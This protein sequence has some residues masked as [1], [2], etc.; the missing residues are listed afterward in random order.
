[1]VVYMNLQSEL[2]RGGVGAIFGGAIGSAIALGTKDNTVNSINS[3]VNKEE[4]EGMLADEY[5]RATY[6]EGEN[7]NEASVYVTYIDA[8]ING[9][10]S[11][12]KSMTPTITP[13]GVNGHVASIESA[14]NYFLEHYN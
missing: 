10:R 7:P 5:L 12:V 14:I 1:M 11:F 3:L 6:T 9:K 8:E 13:D 2:K 4:F